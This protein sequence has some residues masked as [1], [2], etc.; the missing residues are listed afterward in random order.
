MRPF[1]SVPSLLGGPEG[2]ESF[3]SFVDRLSAHQLVP[4]PITTLLS[5][6]GVIAH[7]R[8]DLLP[9][10]YGLDL[11][12]EQRASFAHACRLDSGE[13][14]A[15]LLRSL[16]GTAVNLS[17]L[18]VTDPNSVR[19]VGHREWAGFAGSSCCPACL[20]DT[21]GW[22]LRWKLWTSFACLTHGTL[23]VDVCPRCER[24][25]GGYRAER[26]NAPRFATHVP[27]PGFC[28]NSLPVGVNL[29]GRGA[30]PCGEDLRQVPTL[31]LS[32][33]PRLLDAQRAVNGVIAMRVARVAGQAVSSLTYLGHLR[34]LMALALH[35]AQPGDPGEVPD[36]IARAFSQSC[37]DRDDRRASEAGVRGTALHPYKGAPNDTRLVAAI[38]PWAVELL[39]SPD[40]E[41]VTEGLRPLVE[42]SK[43]IRGSAVRGA[44]RDFHLRGPLEVA[45]DQALAPRA[46]F[47]RTMGHMAPAGTGSYRTFET[48]HVP[49]L[50]WQED[51]ERDFRPLLEGSN[52]GD[53]AARVAISVALVRLTGKHT[54]PASIGL[55]GLEGHSLGASLNPLVMHLGKTGGKDAFQAALHALATRLEG[56][57]PHRDYRAAQEALR[58]FVALDVETWER[59]RM[60]AGMKPNKSAGLRRNTAAWV[61]ATV[62]SSDPYFS[63]ALSADP[64]KQEALREVYRRFEREQLSRLREV[65]GEVVRGMEMG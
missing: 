59:C 35:A 44:A 34:S 39:A 7:D 16:D 38:L 40:Q 41:G 1:S 42:R 26:S 47:H 21:R 25:T 8:H 17:G 37:E 52:I 9:A 64:G 13:L 54:V 20:A 5:R 61:W 4:V 6:A 36:P 45:L 22:R 31:D 57:G 48:R 62:L 19:V 60:A 46:L 33:A 10:G 55:L 53:T 15:M 56:P 49:H 28:A 27:R 14:G 63:P 18:D 58:D 12:P 65:L 2:P 32:G 29:R 11:M 30:R 3:A 51:F 24:R 43:G 23:L 50:I